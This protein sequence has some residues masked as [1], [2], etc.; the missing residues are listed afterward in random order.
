MCREILE[1]GQVLVKRPDREELLAI[2]EGAWSYEQL[3]EWSER[4]DR[5]L[6][7]L[8]HHSPLPAK[9]DMRKL[10]ALCMAM[11][12]EALAEHSS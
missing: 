9:P 1:T 5:A 6:E 8:V 4:E 7:A 11:V 10:D 12:E 2:R 3:V